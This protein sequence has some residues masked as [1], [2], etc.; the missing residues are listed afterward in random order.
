MQHSF[1]SSACGEPLY[2]V[3]I[4]KAPKEHFELNFKIAFGIFQC[5]LDCFGGLLDFNTG[6]KIVI[7]RL[8]EAYGFTT[9][10]AL[11]DQLGVS[12]STMATRYMR[13]IFL[14]DWVL[15]CVLETGVSTDWLETGNG[16]LNTKTDA[17]LVDVVVNE[18]KNGHIT[19]LGTRKIDNFF[20][21]AEIKSPT[22]I[23]FDRKSIYVTKKIPQFLMDN[24]Y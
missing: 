19:H 11:C 15:Q 6:G 7:E 3:I 8:V 13:D 21:N 1:Y 16:E 17:V 20:L 9:C 22:A 2:I 18:L 23:R 14:A 10:Q 12:K 4:V 5:N 24:G